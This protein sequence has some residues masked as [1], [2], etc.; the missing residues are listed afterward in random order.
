MT[1]YLIWW[2]PFCAGGFGD[3]LLGISSS[4]CIAK[5]CGRK[6]MIDWE[7][8][9]ISNFFI[10]KDEYNARKNPVNCRKLLD[11]NT[12]QPRYFS[13][14]DIET[15][16]KGDNILIW[17]NQ[18]LFQYLNNNPKTPKKIDDPYTFLTECLRD[19]LLN[20]FSFHS[21]DVCRNLSN[22][23]VPYDIGIH[24]RIGDHQL[25]NESKQQSH[26]Q[27]IIGYL[28]KIKRHIGD[29]HV[30]VFITSDCDLVYSLARD[31]FN[32]EFNSGPIVHTAHAESRSDEKGLNKV[33][34]DF[35]SLAN[36]CKKIY[37]GWNSNFSRVASLFNTE[38][39]VYCFDYPYNS[40]IVEVPR[41]KRYEYFSLGKF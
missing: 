7:S 32:I 14:V 19:V 3:R 12:E 21:P 31:F 9:D 38:T 20:I 23:H 4:Y 35:S 13:N 25:R 17:S 1:S 33:M 10:I 27:D 40:D 30:S 36:Q 34:L 24:I 37:L 18:N 15:D 8:D 26:R 5:V 28:E 16:W 22:S 2:A 39:I 29:T 11:F 41:N 6:F